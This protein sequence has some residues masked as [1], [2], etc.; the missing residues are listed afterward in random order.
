MGRFHPALRVVRAR[1]ANASAPL[2]GIRNDHALAAVRTTPPDAGRRE[3]TWDRVV[4]VVAAIW[5]IGEREKPTQIAQ[6]TVLLG[7]ERNIR[8]AAGVYEGLKRLVD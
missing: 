2:A 8:H 4:P 5:M 3:K 6:R 1:P 7:V